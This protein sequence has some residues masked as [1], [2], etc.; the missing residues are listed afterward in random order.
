MT[1]SD[2]PSPS[3]C[4]GATPGTCSGDPFR[5]PTACAKGTLTPQEDAL[6]FQL[7]DLSA[8]VSPVGTPPPPPPSTTSIYDPVTFTEDF[9]SSCPTDKHVAW[10]ELDWY[11]DIPNTASIV[12]SAQT[13][14]PPLDG[15]PPDYS[16]AQSVLLFDATMSSP[17]SGQPN[18]VLIDVNVPPDAAMP[19]AFNAAAP[20]VSSQADLRLTITLNPTSDMKASPTLIQWIVKSDCVP[21]E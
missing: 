19:G 12:F 18:G 9:T 17:S 4:Y 16:S 14:N 5:F 15:G 11:A 6:E 1:D 10:R 13:V 8:C 21:T 7:F 2:C 3:S 20:P